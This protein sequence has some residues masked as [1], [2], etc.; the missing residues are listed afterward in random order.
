MAVG[1][2]VVPPNAEAG[3][4]A[5]NTTGEAPNPVIELGLAVRSDAVRGGQS[6]FC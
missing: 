5:G 2:S 1:A 6:R 3:I 4:T